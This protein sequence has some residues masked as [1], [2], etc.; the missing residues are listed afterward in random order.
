MGIGNLYDDGNVLGETREV[1]LAADLIHPRGGGTLW[2]KTK[3]G[4]FTLE[5]SRIQERDFFFSPLLPLCHHHNPHHHTAHF[6]T[7]S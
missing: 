7:I 4:S 2:T 6:M 5:S 3:E 1:Q